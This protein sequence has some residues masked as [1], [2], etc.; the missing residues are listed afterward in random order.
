MATVLLLVHLMIAAA[1]VGV[2]LI[3]RSEGGALGVGGGGGGFMSGRGQA[4]FLTR[5]TAW[6][7]AGFFLTSLGLTLLAQ[8]QTRARSVFDAPAV[9]GTPDAGAV[10][11]AMPNPVTGDAAKPAVPGA[12]APAPN[13]PAP[14]ARGGVLDSLKT[15]SGAAA[16]LPRVPQGQ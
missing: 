5:L 16:P 9:S 7:A 3:Q 2:V 11:G 10:P 14:A 4:N 15:P 1:L 8:Q 13:A 12:E 6:L